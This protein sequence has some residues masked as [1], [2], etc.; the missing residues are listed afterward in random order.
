MND[1][2]IV[3]IGNSQELVHKGDEIIVHRLPG[4]PKTKVAFDEVLLKQT[5]DEITIGTPTIKGLKV[6]AEIIEHTKGEK[7]EKAVYKSKARERRHVGHRQDL[8]K[9]KITN[10]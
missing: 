5:K 1:Y 8:T 10:I 9:I 4:E 3:K 2:V 6:E 7:V